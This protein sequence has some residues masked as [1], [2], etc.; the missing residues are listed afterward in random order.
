MLERVKAHIAQLLHETTLAD[1]REEVAE[2]K[3]MIRMA[4]DTK[5]GVVCRAQCVYHGII[6][7]G[8]GG[9][10]LVCGGVYVLCGQLYRCR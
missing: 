9:C 10:V 8:M 3:A 5:V 1:Q 6:W 7:R 2:G 4:I